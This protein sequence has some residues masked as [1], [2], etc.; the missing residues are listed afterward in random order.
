MDN[1]L[2]R[3]WLVNGIAIFFLLVTGLVLFVLDHLPS[4]VS[5]SGPLAL[6]DFTQRSIDSTILQDL[7]PALPILIGRSHFA[8]VG[9]RV[10]D[11]E[12]PKVRSSYRVAKYYDDEAYESNYT[13]IIFFRDDGF[14][15]K[16]LLDRKAYIS[17]TDIPHAQDSLRS[18]NLYRISYSDTDGDGRIGP[19]DSS[20]LFVSDL[21]GQHLTAVLPSGMR[22]QEYDVA[23]DHHTIRIRVSIRP[24][25]AHIGEQDWPQRLLDYDVRL[26]QLRPNLQVDSTLSVAKEILWSK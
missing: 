1:W 7:R 16:L 6:S 3:I 17:L 8:Y 12:T 23:E 20:N 26:R 18:F 19:G 22:L 21:D 11:L 15:A 24:N 14:K 13:N 5:P 2:R 9:L 10:K 4:R 25:D